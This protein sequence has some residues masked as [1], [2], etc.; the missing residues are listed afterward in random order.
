[1]WSEVAQNWAHFSDELIIDQGGHKIGH[2]EAGLIEA[3]AGNRCLK[4]LQTADSFR[5]YALGP[6]PGVSDVQG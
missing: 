2:S 1:M 5:L 3:D 6:R 4:S